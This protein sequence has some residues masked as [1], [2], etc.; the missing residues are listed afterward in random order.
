MKKIIFAIAL[1]LVTSS[2]FAQ[3]DGS[4]NYS[5]GVKA[6]SIMQMP[7]VLQ[8][9]SNGNYVDAFLN[10][11]MIK[12]NDNQIAI[13]V[14]GHYLYKRDLTFRNQCDNCEN[15]VG[16]MTDYSIKLGFEK[17][18][19]YSTIQPY[20]AAD[21]GFRSNSFN[22]TVN[23]LNPATIK[24]TYAAI[25]SKNGAV[26]TPTFGLKVNLSKQISFFAESSLD[27][28]YSYERQETVLNDPANTRTFAKYNKFETLLNPVS[29]GLQ[30][31][32][33]GKN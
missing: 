30:I 19:N 21:F 1:L 16:N 17:N 14:S 2:S 7:K 3:L 10:G 28:F 6:Y 32:L 9:T 20:F 8:Q 25:T 24:T 12:F 33:L 23:Q 15:A 11:G 27:L 18:F 29:V 22:G 13:R 31:Q 5:I 4:Y 26:A